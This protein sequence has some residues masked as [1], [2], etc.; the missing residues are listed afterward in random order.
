MAAKLAAEA[1]IQS[2]PSVAG[3]KLR[4]GAGEEGLFSGGMARLV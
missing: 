4:R 3:A 1:S 2:A